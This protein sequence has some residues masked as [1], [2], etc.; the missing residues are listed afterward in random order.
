MVALCVSWHSFGG[1][2]N[3]PLFTSKRSSFSPPYGVR[4]G[5][6]RSPDIQWTSSSLLGHIYLARL[7]GVGL[8]VRYWRPPDPSIHLAPPPPNLFLPLPPAPP[9]TFRE[10]LQYIGHTL[11]LTIKLLWACSWTQFVLRILLCVCE[12]QLMLF[13]FSLQYW[14]IFS[15]ASHS[16]LHPPHKA[17][18][19]RE[20]RRGEENVWEWATPHSGH[21][22][23]P[24]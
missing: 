1:I 16:P 13:F 6:L 20:E 15:I 4:Y 14:A 17:S 9:T 11:R 19:A 23:S 8:W 5:R 3:P 21:I 12:F 18:E 24:C 10:P 22:L 2:S 7:G